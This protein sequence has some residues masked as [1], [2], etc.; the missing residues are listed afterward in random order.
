M[1][2]L[3]PE[4]FFRPQLTMSDSEL[5]ELLELMR[6]LTPHNDEWVLWLMFTEMG[7]A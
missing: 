3:V 2:S 1:N 5:I 4:L 7:I 6:D